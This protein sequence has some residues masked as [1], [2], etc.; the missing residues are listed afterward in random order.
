MQGDRFDTPGAP[1][2]LTSVWKEYQRLT[3]FPL[4]RTVTDAPIPASIAYA[5]DKLQGCYDLSTVLDAVA[6]V[7]PDGTASMR[8]NA[9]PNP[10]DVLN[11][12]DIDPAGT[13]VDV[14]PHLA[15][16]NV[17]N[18]VVVR[19]TD[20]AG[21][22][23]VLASAEVSDG[24]LRTRNADGSLSPYRRRPYY[25]QSQL[26]T[27]QAQAQAYANQMLPRVSKLRSIT[28]DLVELFNPLR[29]VGDVLTVNRLGGSF[30][31]RVTDIRRDSGAT[32]T[33][34]VAVNQ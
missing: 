1:P 9:W 12:A 28:Y 6:Y 20:P 17:Y 34:T 22:T 31:C 23:I 32:Q 24:Q 7:T 18:A 2:D 19:G 13:L 10:V 30:T 5:E 8:P 33:L 21:Q 11:S 15:N 4:T 25:V 29:E 14:V 3:G 27:T 26:I 16:D